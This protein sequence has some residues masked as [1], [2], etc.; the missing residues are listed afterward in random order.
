MYNHWPD[1]K[2][3]RSRP[4]FYFDAVLMG[5]PPPAPGAPTQKGAERK[6]GKGYQRPLPIIFTLRGPAR[7]DRG[8]VPRLAVLNLI[9][10][11]SRRIA[12]LAAQ[13]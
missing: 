6:K 8:Q 12:L 13:K 3:P 9:T 1:Y 5:T 10:P 2:I 11:G 4:F 7:S